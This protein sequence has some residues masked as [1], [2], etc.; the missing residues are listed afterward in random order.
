MAMGRVAAFTCDLLDDGVKLE[1]SPSAEG[2]S[3]GSASPNTPT[4]RKQVAF[5]DSPAPLVSSDPTRSSSSTPDLPLGAPVISM[6][7]PTPRQEGSLP[8]PPFAVSPPLTRRRGSFIDDYA[9]KVVEVAGTPTSGPAKSPTELLSLCDVLAQMAELRG[10]MAKV[11]QEKEVA[12]KELESTRD[13]ISNIEA[14][15]AELTQQMVKYFESNGRKYLEWAQSEVEML[16]RRL[17]VELFV[18]SSSS[19]QKDDTESLVKGLEDWYEKAKR[20]ADDALRA[21]V[22][23]GAEKRRLKEQLTKAEAKIASL[24]TDLLLAQREI[25]VLSHT[26]RELTHEFT[27]QQLEER[28]AN[29]ESR[30]ATAEAAASRLR[31]ELEVVREQ[32]SLQMQQLAENRIEV[33]LP[34]TPTPDALLKTVVRKKDV[35]TQCWGRRLSSHSSSESSEMW[36]PPDDGF[37]VLVNQTNLA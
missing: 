29:A 31:D 16:L 37:V 8:S 24:E 10:D 27:I 26:P 32:C 2:V 30:T 15:Y 11:T 7:A 21:S 33:H 25:R 18:S 4:V 22:E 9:E 19:L 34:R 35:A 13:T 14:L 6:T 5:L 12:E 36:T 17:E 3:V 1:S 20:D 28:L 23:V